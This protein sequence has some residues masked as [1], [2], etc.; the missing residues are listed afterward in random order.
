MER[1][2]NDPI[3]EGA[4]FVAEL[5]AQYGCEALFRAFSGWDASWRTQPEMWM[6]ELREEVQSDLEGLA[7][8]AR[9]P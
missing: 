4:S 3:E 5:S 7:E 8:T 9:D 6:A 1:E 2:G